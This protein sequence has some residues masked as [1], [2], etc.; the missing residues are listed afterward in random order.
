[1]SNRYLTRLS[2]LE[3]QRGS[4]RGKSRSLTPEQALAI[5][6]EILGCSPEALGHKGQYV[7]KFKPGQAKAIVER[8]LFGPNGR[9]AQTQSDEAER[10]AP[11]STE[12]R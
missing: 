4:K 11:P 2:R 7:P 6:I 5:K 3:Q 8:I 1:M 9:P 10:H 12:F